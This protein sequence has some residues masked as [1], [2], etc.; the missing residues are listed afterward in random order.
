MATIAYLTRFLHASVLIKQ[1]IYGFTPQGII[2][3]KVRRKA[4]TQPED[5]LK[6]AIS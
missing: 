5:A 2:G 1:V 4:M 6:R 3:T